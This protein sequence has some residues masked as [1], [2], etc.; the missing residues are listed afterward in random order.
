MSSSLVNWT[1]NF[2]VSYFFLA[3][4]M[5]IGARRDLLV[6]RFLRPV[7][8]AFSLFKVPETAGRSLEQ[9]EHDIGAESQP[10]AAS[11]DLEEGQDAAQGHQGIAVLERR[12]LGEEPADG[13]EGGHQA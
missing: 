12:R 11:A 10:E 2:L 4:T 9:I 7:R 13:R 8:L 3:L 5:T 6:L 1:F